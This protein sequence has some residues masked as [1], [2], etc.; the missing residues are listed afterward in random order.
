MKRLTLLLVLLT[1]SLLL[2]A[3]EGL[4]IAGLFGQSTA[5]AH[6]ENVT[7]THLSGKK[8]KVYRLSLFR[9]LKVEH[10]TGTDIEK[11]ERA[12]RADAA[13]AVDKQLLHRGNSI[14]Y[15]FCKLPD[16]QGLHRYLIYR[17]KA[18]KNGRDNELHLIYMEGTASPEELEQIFR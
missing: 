8:L 14:H 11:M 16:R 1:S 7:E 10:A 9:S 12:V 18:T 3:Q 13:R 15:A 4:S 5:F 17:N 2:S 6:P